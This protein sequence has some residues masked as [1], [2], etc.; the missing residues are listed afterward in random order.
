MASGPRFSQIDAALRSLQGR[1]ANARSFALGTPAQARTAA[2]TSYLP[3]QRQGRSTQSKP[4]H[5]GGFKG[6]LATALESPVGKAL[7]AVDLPRSYLTSHISDFAQ[8]VEKGDVVGSIGALGRTIPGLGVVGE[9]GDAVDGKGFNLGQ[10]LNSY[11]NDKNR[12][13]EERRVGKECRSRWSPY[14]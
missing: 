4:S 10:V 7:K 2:L 13:S 5:P 12:R 6:L 11:E 8:Q 3:V 1:P 14:H 9:I